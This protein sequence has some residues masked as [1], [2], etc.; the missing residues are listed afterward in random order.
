MKMM[1]RKRKIKKQNLTW[2]KEETCTEKKDKSESLENE[3]GVLEKKNK[4]LKSKFKT[5]ETK[6]QIFKILFWIFCNLFVSI[7]HVLSAWALE[8]NW[9][10]ELGIKDFEMSNPKLKCIWY[11]QHFTLNPRPTLQVYSMFLH[12]C[13]IGLEYCNSN[14]IK[15][16]LTKHRI[17]IFY[18]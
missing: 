7:F 5:T 9:I 13:L 17:Q 16:P 18:I 3:L 4:D 2:V 12:I 14:W 8:L 15:L 10:G 1:K 6:K 11:W